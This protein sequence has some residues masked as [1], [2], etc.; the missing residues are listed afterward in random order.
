MSTIEAQ[1]STLTLSEA[2]VIDITGKRRQTEQMNVLKALGIPSR[3]RYDNSVLVLRMHCV[4]S[5][6]VAANDEPAPKL[7]KYKK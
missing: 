1:P 2:E 3:R 6:R 7:K 4:H 5:G